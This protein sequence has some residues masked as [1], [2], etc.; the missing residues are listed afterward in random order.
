MC[1]P[2]PPGVLPSKMAR[3][4]RITAQF[5]SCDPRPEIVHPHFPG[6]G[7]GCLRAYFEKPAAPARITVS[8]PLWPAHWWSGTWM[9]W[10][11]PCI[12]RKLLSS[13]GMIS[14]CGSRI[15]LPAL[16]FHGLQV[17][18]QESFREEELNGA[19]CPPVM[20]SEE[21]GT[22][23]SLQGPPPPTRHLVCPGFRQTWSG[24]GPG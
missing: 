12:S 22:R 1:V 5:R 7:G 3:W 15:G 10:L 9:G 11:G 24:T 13:K 23:R 8:L 2:H 21:K 20:A 14:L 19:D 18:A 16:Q 6:P 17:L 4:V